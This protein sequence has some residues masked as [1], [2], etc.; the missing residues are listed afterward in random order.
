MKELSIFFRVLLLALVG[1]LLSACGGDGSGSGGGPVRMQMDTLSVRALAIEGQGQDMAV[2]TETGQAVSWVGHLVFYQQDSQNP[3]RLLNLGTADL[4]VST[5]GSFSIADLSYGPDWAVATIESNV[6]GV[7]TVN[8]PVFKRDFLLQVP[9][10]VKASATG[11]WLLVATSTDLRLYDISNPATPTPSQTISSG[12][13]TIGMV[14]TMNGFFVS[15]EGGYLFIDPMNL[16]NVT[17]ITNPDLAKAQKVYCYGSKLY[18]AGPSK[19]AGKS[20][21]ARVDVSVPENPAIEIL[22]D[23]IDGEYFDFAFDGIDTCH[24]LIDGEKIAKYKF[25]QNYLTFMGAAYLTSYG[26]KA[27]QIFSHKGVCYFS[28]PDGLGIFKF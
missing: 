8:P 13:Q 2:L 16:G 5:Q 4:G 11:N 15:T 22:E 12:T 3:D 23:T 20:K 14:A 28:S 24:I 7:S 6:T 10:A 21:I 18:L 19:F 9:G 26:E 25:A 1:F 27:S 17:K